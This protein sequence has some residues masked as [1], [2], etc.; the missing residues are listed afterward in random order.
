M[1]YEATV[2]AHAKANIF[3]EITGKRSDGFHDLISL[4]VPIF[5][6]YDEVKMA[7][8][9]STD[10][11]FT[12]SDEQL[13]KNT[14][15][16]TA[17]KAAKLLLPYKNVKSGVEIH[18]N[19]SLPYGAGLGSASSDAVAVL[20]GLNLLWKCDLSREKL[21]ALS[22]LVG[23]DCPFFF[24][25]SSCIVRGRGELLEP[26]ENQQPFYLM[27][28]KPK[29]L[30]ISTVEAYR[31]LAEKKL[32]SNNTQ[33]Q[34][35]VFQAFKQGGISNLGPF[36]FNSFESA[37]KESI[38][39]ISEMKQIMK[40]LGA[41]VSVMSGSGSAVVGLFSDGEALNEAKGDFFEKKLE[42]RFDFCVSVL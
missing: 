23:S 32:Y 28:I 37:L 15:E 16:N 1:I 30:S 13:Q 5:D 40:S 25:D 38:P 39:E 4:F 12:C 41:S 14:E 20:Q 27:V 34:S 35:K 24:Y 2:R 26:I 10:V 8:T 33:R 7:L 17:V 19:K 29:E 31:A 36:L 11:V 21:I 42:K 3:L 9:D 22:L 18:L 6:W